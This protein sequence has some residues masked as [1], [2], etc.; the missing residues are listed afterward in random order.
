MYSFIFLIKFQ[1]NSKEGEVLI[2][3]DENTKECKQTLEKLIGKK[4]IDIDFKYYDDECWRVYIGT[5]KG[6]MV[7]TFCKKW[8][9]PVVELRK[10]ISENMEDYE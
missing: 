7:M 1:Y 4:I 2:D 9:C 10:D 5:D 8:G 3:L 6:K